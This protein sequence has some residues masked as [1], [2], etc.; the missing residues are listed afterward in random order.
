MY[1][2]FIKLLQVN[3]H[4]ADHQLKTKVRNTFYKLIFFFLILNS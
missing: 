4:L 2:D 3:D 1:K